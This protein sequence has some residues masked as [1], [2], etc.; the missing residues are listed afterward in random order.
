MFSW[1][2]L[3][4][5]TF[6]TEIPDR[7]SSLQTVADLFEASITKGRFPKINEKCIAQSLAGEAQE[8]Q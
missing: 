4:E 3:L 2:K 6:N 1:H 7:P 5:L 8:N